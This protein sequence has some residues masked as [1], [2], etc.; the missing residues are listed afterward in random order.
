[1]I[2][3]GS[4]ILIFMF[5]KYLHK[6]SNKRYSTRRDATRRDATRLDATRLDATNATRR[7]STRRNATFSINII[8]IIFAGQPRIK[9]FV[10]MT[11]LQL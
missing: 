8:F 7:N 4:R 11:F 9:P 1:M 6:Y 2:R 5:S 10:L 3:N